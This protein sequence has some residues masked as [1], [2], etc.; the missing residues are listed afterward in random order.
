MK[1]KEIF[2]AQPFPEYD[3]NTTRNITQKLENAKLVSNL[4][5]GKFQLFENNQLYMLVRTADRELIG[6]AVVSVYDRIENILA[7]EM[8]YVRPTFRKTKAATLLLMGIKR[9]LNVSLVVDGP[10]SPAE[11]RLL[12]NLDRTH[13][14]VY[15]L[16]VDTGEKKQYNGEELPKYDRKGNRI[17]LLIEQ[18]D[19][20]LIYED[21]IPGVL[22]RTIVLQFFNNDELKEM[23]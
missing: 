4:E 8:I 17:V 11:Q 10:T 13:L 12:S 7:I 6:W 23:L 14:P 19:T 21:V 2:S 5:G 20:P 1:L 9:A 16:N 3:D 18:D 22:Q 15:W